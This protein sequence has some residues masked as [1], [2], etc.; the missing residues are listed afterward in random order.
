MS[1]MK[2]NG[3]DDRLIRDNRTMEKE[4]GVEGLRWMHSQVARMV[5]APYAPTYRAKAG[6]KNLH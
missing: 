1:Y 3:D 5:P 6:K 4:Y 2:I